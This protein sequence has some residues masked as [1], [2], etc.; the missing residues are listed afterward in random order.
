MVPLCELCPTL[1]PSGS[2]SVHNSCC[3]LK[4]QLASVDLLEPHMAKHGAVSRA[5]QKAYQ[6][7]PHLRCVTVMGGGKGEGLAERRQESQLKYQ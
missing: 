3:C 6:S 1:V 2:S 7:E 4:N 5:F